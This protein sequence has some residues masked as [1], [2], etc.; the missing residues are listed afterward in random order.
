MNGYF[1]APKTGV[2]RVNFS[3]TTNFDFGMSRNQNKD[4]TKSKIS[5]RMKAIKPIAGILHLFLLM[6]VAEHI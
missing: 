5:D 1:Y 4:E 2:E 6:V 3:I